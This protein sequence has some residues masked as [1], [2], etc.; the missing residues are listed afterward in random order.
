MLV[1]FNPFFDE[2]YSLPKKAEGTS[3]SVPS[4]F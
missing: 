3:N 1:I 2:P 4:A